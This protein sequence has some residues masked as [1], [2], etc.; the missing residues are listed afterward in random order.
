MKVFRVGI[1]GLGSIGL[2]M[3]QAFDH[4]E[5]FAISKVFDPSS[6]ACS[7][8]RQRYPQLKFAPDIDTFYASKDLDLIY[9]ACPPVAHRARALRALDTAQAV[10]C[11]KPLG[12]SLAESADLVAQVAASGLPNAVNLLYA[13]SR[14]SVGLEDA[15]RRDDVGDLA[16]V[17]IHLH[18]PQWAQRRYAEAPW[19]MERSQGGFVREV[20]THYLFLC[21]RLFGQLNLA[22][23]HVVYPSD[24]ISAVT[25]ADVLLTAGSTRIT[26]TGSTL[27]AGPELN[28]VNFWGSNTAYRIRD[29]HYLDRFVK[30]DWVPAVTHKNR[31]ELD[32]YLN[33]LDNLTAMLEGRPHRLPDFSEAFETQKLVEAILA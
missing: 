2:R 4:H 19:L 22:S 31:P 3:L 25:F 27:G 21:Q 14:A 6:A 29:L 8:A 26:L 13:S 24:G 28:H 33:Q 15:L 32:T 9:I 5:R 10:F 18:L 30:E 20:A 23:C 7:Q 17:D 12:V 1:V 11:E 16:W